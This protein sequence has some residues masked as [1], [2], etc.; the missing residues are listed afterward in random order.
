MARHARIQSATGIYHIIMRGIN[1]QS[2]FECREDFERFKLCIEK[3]KEVSEIKVLA[4]CL[5]CNHVHIVAGVGSE[6]LG[7]SFKRI[8]VRYAYWYNRKYNRQ[9]PLFQ[10]RY[11]SEPI[12]DDTYLLTAVRYVHQNPIKAGLCKEPKEYEWSSFADYVG[13]WNEITD[14]SLVLGIYSKDPTEQIRLFEEFT[15]KDNDD[16]FE[17]IGD[18]I[19]VSDTALR[20][21]MNNICHAS[22]AEEFQALS[23]EERNQSLL[24]MRNSGM[25]IRQI[26]QQTGESYWAVQSIGR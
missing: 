13:E 3:V 11:R 20:E 26:V 6:P 1:K 14:T 25:S 5:M 2:I 19:C 24:A 21:R 16:E 9:G 23:R 10:D 15:E 7:V 22:N 17:D 12:E 4:Y 18:E 8:G